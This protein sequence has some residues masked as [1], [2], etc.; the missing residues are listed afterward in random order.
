MFLAYCHKLWCPVYCYEPFCLSYCS[1]HNTLTLP[2]WPVYTNFCTWPYN[3]LLHN[4]PPISLHM[5][6]CSS[7]HTVS[8]LC[9]YCS[10]SNI[11]MP[12]RSVPLSHQTV[13][14]LH[15]L[16][17]SVCNIFVKWYLVYNVWS[18]AAII[19]LPVYS[20]RSSL[21]S[22]NNVSSAPISCLYTLI[23]YWPCST[24][25]SHF[26]FTNSPIFLLPIE[27]F[28]FLFNCYLLNGFIVLQHLLLF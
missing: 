19:P 2:S 23:I 21:N 13:Y 27:C 9:M 15:L 8:C 3:C 28:P 24:L 17:V 4:F 18:C 7:A 14:S 6:Q 10:V 20:F 5:L 11:D 22:H 16:S 25:F 26:I 12:I 1:F